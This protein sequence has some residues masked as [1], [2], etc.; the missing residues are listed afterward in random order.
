[1]NG[2]PERF[3]LLGRRL[4]PRF[5]TRLVVIEPSRSHRYVPD[6]WLDALVVVEFGEIEL[7][8]AGSRALRF[9]AGEVL[10]LAGLPVRALRNRGMTPTGLLVVGRR[11]ASG[12]KALTRFFRHLRLSY[13]RTRQCWS[14]RRNREEVMMNQE[15]RTLVRARQVLRAVSAQSSSTFANQVVAFVVPWLVLA[16]TGSALNAGA[17]AFT[18]GVAAVLGTV[19]GGIVVDQIGPRRTSLL[20]DALSLVTVVALPVALFADFLPLWL[21]ITT[22]TLGIFFDGPGKVA[23]DTL[24][25]T[26]A[27]RDGVPLVRVA[28]LQESLQGVATLVGPL[29]AGLAIA[30]FGEGAALMLAAAVFGL[31]MLL[32]FGIER[33]AV[34]RDEPLTVQGAYADMR[35]GFSYLLHEPLLGP[36]TLLLVAWVAS[37]VPLTTIVLPAWFVFDGQGAGSLGLFLG[38]QALGGIIGGLGFAAIGPKVRPYRWF[39]ASNVVSKA[40]LASLLLSRPGSA[41]A[42]AIAFLIGLTAAGQLPIINTAYY[43]RTPKHILGR[44]NAAGWTLVLAA[45]PFASLLMGWFVNAA[46][47]WTGIAVVVAA[48][49]VMIGIFCTIP[50]MRL[51]D[52][53]P[54]EHADDAASQVAVHAGAAA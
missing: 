31:A 40:A 45:L 50:A 4:D 3:S 16:R 47:P 19:L 22:Q 27:T 51:L 21:I 37:F 7:E 11:R 52:D 35:D 12:P 33:D 18:T 26:V 38:A 49:V 48:N 28:S 29:A 10:W 20:S 30:A 2:Q 39:I 6:D 17:V 15:L 54:N 1:M 8:C 44:V 24:V 25:P 46:S 32:V 53:R 5:V 34:V 43:T 9:G 13:H 36:L 23:R 41:A 14:G 42:V